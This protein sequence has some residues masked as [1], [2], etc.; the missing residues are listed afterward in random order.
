[1]PVSRY[2]LDSEM[3]EVKMGSAYSKMRERRNA[4]RILIRNPLRRSEYNT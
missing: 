1:M 2:C 4:E 3:W